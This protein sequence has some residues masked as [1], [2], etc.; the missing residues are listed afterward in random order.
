MAQGASWL[1]T[2]VAS[3]WSGGRALVSLFSLLIITPVVAF[4]LLC[5]WDRSLS[6]VDNWIPVHHRDTVRG[7]G[8]RDRCGDR[9]LCA[10]TGGDLPH[11][12][13]VLCGRLDTESASTSGS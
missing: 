13:L 10:R 12:R 6:T 5:D 2:F 7:A 1:A 4:Y 3:L 8:A 11:P 9:R